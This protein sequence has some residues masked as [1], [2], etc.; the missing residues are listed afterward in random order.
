MHKNQEY[1]LIGREKLKSVFP[2]VEWKFSNQQHSAFDAL[3][4]HKGKTFIAE[5]K[6]RRCSAF[7]FD[8]CFL[9]KDKLI[10]ISSYKDVD[11]ILYVVHYDNDITCTWNLTTMDFENVKESTCLMNARTGENLG[12]IHKEVYELN[13]N[14][15]DI[16]ITSTAK[17]IIKQ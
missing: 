14:D 12:K 17:K 4:Y 11:T 16:R 6:T 8:T 2:T 9:E 3:A 10:A 15:A 5:I 7:Q 13:I 1:E